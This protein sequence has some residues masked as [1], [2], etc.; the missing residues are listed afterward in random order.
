MKPKVTPS[1]MDVAHW[2]IIRQNVESSI[3]AWAVEFDCEGKTLLDIA[4]QDYLGARQFWSK[5]RVVTLDIDQSAKA[6]YTADI[7]SN[8]GIPADSFDFILCTEVLEHTLLPFH[9]VAEMHRLLKPS[10]L[11]LLSVPFNFRIHGPLPDCWR[12]TEH[13][14]RALLGNSFNDT[15]IA[16]IA[17]PDRPLMPIHYTVSARKR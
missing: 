1:E 13:G 14:I 7:C 9:A 3:R 11:L 10:G 8:T 4:P 16:E 2:R 5:C 12:F 17:T 15:R 6:D